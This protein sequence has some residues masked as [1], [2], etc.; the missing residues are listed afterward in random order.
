MESALPDSKQEESQYTSGL[1]I[2]FLA[3]VGKGRSRFSPPIPTRAKSFA[4][5]KLLYAR[6]RSVFSRKAKLSLTPSYG[7]TR[8]KKERRRFVDSDRLGKSWE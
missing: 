8:E 2:S 7:A 3:A 4:K 6:E 5:T 1:V